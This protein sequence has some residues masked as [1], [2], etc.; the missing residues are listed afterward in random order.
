[1]SEE[2]MNS[3]KEK[4]LKYNERSSY[5]K[6][7]VCDVLGHDENHM[8]NQMVGELYD[9]YLKEK[10]LPVAIEEFQMSPMVEVLLN[11][12]NDDEQV[13][14]ST[15]VV[16]GFIKP[17]SILVVAEDFDG[18]SRLFMGMNEYLRKYA[19]MFTDSLAIDRELQ[20]L[21][22]PK[23]LQKVAIIN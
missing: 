13:T 16:N 14:F 23:Q 22:E 6:K 2:L 5:I 21:K 9:N 1:M 17:I 12:M 19:I 18:A 4:C 15:N 20:E 8:F 10:Y 11:K 7:M 3:F